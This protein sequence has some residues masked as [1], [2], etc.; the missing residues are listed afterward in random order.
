VAA[1]CWLQLTAGSVTG[2]FGKASQKLAHQLLDDS[3]VR[4]VA[5]DAHNLG[6]RPP[7]LS[8]AHALISRQWDT[9]LADELMLHHPQ[10]ILSASAEAGAGA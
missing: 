3:A 1:G 5:S 2:A 6:A 7:V 8:Q 9:D 10:R 4:V